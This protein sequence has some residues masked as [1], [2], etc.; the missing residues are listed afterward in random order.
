MAFPSFGFLFGD[1]VQAIKIL[2]DIHKALQDVGGAE[3]EF[4]YGLVDVQQLEILLD[5][6]NRGSWDEGGD[7]GYLNAVKGMALTCQ[8]PV[9]EFLAKIDS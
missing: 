7:V 3:D 2:N 1:F 8:V 9:Q 6:L 4:K 5:Q